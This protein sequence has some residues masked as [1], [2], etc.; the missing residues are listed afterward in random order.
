V[1]ELAAGTGAPPAQDEFARAY[2]TYAGMLYRYAVRRLGPEPAEDLVAE[3]F[4][5]A[6]AQWDR[7]DPARGE[8][9]P[10]LFGI[11]TN[12]IARHHREEGARLRTLAA[13]PPPAVADDVAERTSEAV[14]A[15]A[16]RSALMTAIAGLRPGD[17]DVLL[18]VAWAELTYSEVAG[19]LGVPVGT[20]RSRLNR[21]RRLLR[22]R[23]PADW[24]H[25]R[26]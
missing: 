1:P 7:Y 19:V 8:V 5:A 11:L 12:K 4:T 20:V 3:T 10:W 9:R 22:D 18:L 21:A 6:F 25:D 26:G 24:R 23:L 2:D 13:M 15:A 16:A 17:R 14:S